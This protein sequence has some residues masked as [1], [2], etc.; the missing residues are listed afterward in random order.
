MLSIQLSVSRPWI[1]LATS[2]VALLFGYCMS[3]GGQEPGEYI[4]PTPTPKPF[5]RTGLDVLCESDFEALKGKRI[6]LFADHTAVDRNGI[7]ITQLLLSHPAVTLAGL[8]G[9]EEQVWGGKDVAD[10][11][12]P[13]GAARK[14]IPVFGEDEA[15]DFSAP[16][17]ISGISLDAV[18]FDSQDN[19]L[20]WR[21]GVSLMQAAM[22]AASQSGL[23][24]FVLDRP[25]PLGG[26]TVSGPVQH[27]ETNKQET[28]F[29]V[30]L[31]HGMT[32]GELARMAVGEKW[33]PS[34]TAFAL[35]VVQVEGWD[36]ELS[37]EQVDVGWVPRTQHLQYP[38]RMILYAGMCLFEGT[39][40]S[41]GL[42][43]EQEYKQ[44]GA[45]WIESAGIYERMERRRLPA[46]TFAPVH[47][48]PEV[49]LDAGVDPIY[50]GQ[51]C[52]GVFIGFLDNRSFDPLRA[53]LY[54]LAD[55]AQNYPKKLRFEEEFDEI[56]AREG[57]DVSLKR[58]ANPDAILFSW[59]PEIRR[60]RIAR[61]PYLLYR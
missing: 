29:P 12:G 33:I 45:P 60:F 25:N 55:V 2:C 43:T 8:V 61:G 59:Q 54:V 58:G 24:F 5:V 15:L 6:L 53:A 14:A 36:R 31:R 3:A 52:Q 30:P 48:T 51:L 21:G 41:V 42:G 20:R 27:C 19:G 22:N 10:S 28:C 13:V 50:A 34:A 9:D 39:N 23:P 18:V 35:K 44:V 49:D 26:L 4:E 46:T 38:N 56:I 32:L 11:T 40:L 7:H 16:E 17:K 1:I 57:I 47:F 37:L